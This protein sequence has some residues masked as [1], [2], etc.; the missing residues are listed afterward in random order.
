MFKEFAATLLA[1]SPVALYLD[2]LA[3]SPV[4]DS[5]LSYL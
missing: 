3:G 1:L 4:L 5:I 2:H